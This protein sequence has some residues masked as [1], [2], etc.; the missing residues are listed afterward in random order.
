[1]VET[2]RFWNEVA[3]LEPDAEY[4]AEFAAW[5]RQ[6]FGAGIQR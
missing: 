5:D 4:L 6:D 1:L 2:E 3:L